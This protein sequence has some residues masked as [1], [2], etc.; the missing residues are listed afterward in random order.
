MIC[1]TMPAVAARLLAGSLVV[2]LGVVSLSI[3]LAS[4]GYT[5]AD[6]S[7]GVAA[8]LVAGWAL[9]GAGALFWSTHPG[10]ATG[11]LLVGAGAL[12]FIAEW[13]SPAV[14]AA[15]VFTA[16]LVLQAA[17]P[18]IVAMAVFAYPG[19]TI[20]SW[21]ARIG[22]SAFLA[23]TVVLIGG[24]TLFNDP[25]AQGCRECARNVLLLTTDAAR[26]T[27]LG[28]AGIR[29]GFVAALV[30]VG[31]GVWRLARATPAGR[32]ALG[33]VLVA[34][35]IYLGV[36]AW[37]LGANLDRAFVGTGGSEQRRWLIQAL[38]LTLVAAAVVWGCA[39]QRRTR[40]AL[41]D[42]VVELGRASAGGGL[43]DALAARLGDPTLEVAYAVGPGRWVGP[44]G[45]PTC[46]VET[47]DRTSTPLIRNGEEVARLVHRR[48]LLDDADALD[49]VATS[50]QLLVD[51]ERLHA[52]ARATELELRAS[53]A[54]IVEA[55]DA[56]RRR[57]E[58]D[59]HDGAQ[60]RL[61]GL[62]LGVRMTSRE[63][64][65]VDSPDVVSL[66]GAER[67]IMAAV[68]SLRVI[69]NGIYPGSL[70]SFGLSEAL[71]SLAER[72]SASVEVIDLPA[73]RLPVPVE[74]CVYHVVAALVAAGDVVVAVSLDD[75]VLSL[76][77]DAAAVPGQLVDVE[78]R[79]GALDGMLR[80]GA[81][82]AGRVAVR[83]ELACVS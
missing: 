31:A 72:S 32:R 76:D 46:V 60:Q 40:R 63:A 13:D 75:G 36:V 29:V 80:V 49:A 30:L 59:L 43:R 22:L 24:A 53:R 44:D 64:A 45:G 78:D 27:A 42:I 21:P 16:G 48:S 56:E 8:L 18:A 5:F 3:A 14:G 79:V 9:A 68:E 12:W 35:M 66:A 33:P 39:R 70:T 2:V 81:T 15:P 55:S 50:V 52:V 28:R 38:A 73:D 1:A 19:G 10:N 62:I 77:V 54:R 69:A 34:G 57:L 82:A 4:G 83:A 74:T 7:L 26:A 58:R 47:V 25:G 37:S 71:R 23:G 6:S 67:E 65:V 11:P 17:C 61:V 41:V 20:R 51:N